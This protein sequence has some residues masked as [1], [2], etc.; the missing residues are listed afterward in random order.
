MAL[1]REDSTLSRAPATRDA[2]RRKLAPGTKILTTLSRQV[3][4]QWAG[5]VA[6]KKVDSRLLPQQLSEGIIK[7]RPLACLVLNLMRR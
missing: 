4:L 7:R 3:C 6:L 1:K 5:K 2:K